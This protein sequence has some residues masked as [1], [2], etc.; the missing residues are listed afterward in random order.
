MPADGPVVAVGNGIRRLK[1]PID[2]RMPPFHCKVQMKGGVWRQAKQVFQ[3]AS[4]IDLGACIMRNLKY[5]CL[6]VT[7]HFPS[8]VDSS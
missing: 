1:Q 7:V 8:F 2:H 6:K 3:N 5:A 4:N